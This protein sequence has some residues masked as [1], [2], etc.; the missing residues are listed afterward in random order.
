MAHKIIF[1]ELP[2]VNNV[3]PTGIYE[4]EIKKAE[5]TH[6]KMDGCLQI[7]VELRVVSKEFNGRGHWEFFQLGQIGR[8]VQSDKEEWVAL[9]AIDDPDFTDP[10]LIRQSPTFKRFRTMAIAS[11]YKFP[12]EGDLEDVVA[13][14]VGRRVAAKVIVGVEQYGKRKGED[15]NIIEKFLPVG[16][17]TAGATTE[18]PGKSKVVKPSVNGVRPKPMMTAPVV[19]EED[20]EIDMFEDEQ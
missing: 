6:R 9:C 15:K 17:V 14:M 12:H 7:N 20:E 3:L 18:T 5:L 4:F 19:V 2:G 1:G 16:S 8:Q 10:E 11:G 13:D